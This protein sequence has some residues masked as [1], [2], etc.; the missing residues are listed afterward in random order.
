[1]RLYS[2][3]NEQGLISQQPFGLPCGKVQARRLH[4]FSIF[5]YKKNCPTCPSCL[6]CPSKIVKASKPAVRKR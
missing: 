5:C 3:A 6:T 2:T 1:M 4:S